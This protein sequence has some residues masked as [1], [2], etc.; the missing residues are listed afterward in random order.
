ME[1]PSTLVHMSILIMERLR[2]IRSKY[3]GFGWQI[4]MYVVILEKNICVFFLYMSFQKIFWIPCLLCKDLTW[5]L[6]F[7]M[8]CLEFAFI[9][10]PSLNICKYLVD[11]ASSNWAL[12]AANHQDLNADVGN[13]IEIIGKIFLLVYTIYFLYSLVKHII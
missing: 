11:W 4:R 3:G 5:F 2:F 10:M 8:K 7:Y 6:T 1:L 13:G 12:E 9:C